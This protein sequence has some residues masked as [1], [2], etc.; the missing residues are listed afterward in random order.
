MNNTTKIIHAEQDP[1]IISMNEKNQ[2]VLFKQERVIC[3]FITYI[4]ALSVK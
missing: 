4:V 3:N 2:M 1:L